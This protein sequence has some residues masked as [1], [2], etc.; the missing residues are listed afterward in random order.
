MKMERSELRDRLNVKKMPKQAPKRPKYI[1][2]FFKINRTH[3]Y[4]DNAGSMYFSNV[5][6]VSSKSEFH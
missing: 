4:I 3:R 1:I 2:Y 5:L 6:P